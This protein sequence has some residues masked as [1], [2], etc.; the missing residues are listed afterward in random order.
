MLPRGGGWWRS[1]RHVERDDGALGASAMPGRLRRSITEF[2]SVKSR[3]PAR[4]GAVAEVGRHDLRDQV[5]DLRPDA[6]KRGD[7]HEQR[8]EEGRAH[9]RQLMRRAT[10]RKADRPRHPRYMRR[11][12]TRMRMMTGTT[13]SSEGL[14]P[15]RRKL[16]FRSWHRGMREM[17][18]IL[19]SFRRRQHRR[20]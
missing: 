12:A 6:G 2:G 11:S 14:D 19:G 10:M 16:L 3:S 9:V 13:R 18:L 7:R 5:G 20:A 15:R 8:V 17:D 1:T 4:A